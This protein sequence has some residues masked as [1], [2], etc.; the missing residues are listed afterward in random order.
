MCRLSWRQINLHTPTHWTPPLTCRPPTRV[1]R[2]FIHSTA[3][4]L[5]F[6]KWAM[7]NSR[8][9]TT[10]FSCDANNRLT[11]INY[12]DGSTAAYTFDADGDRLNM[13]DAHGITSCAYDQS[14]PLGRPRAR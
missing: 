13:V 6:W 14:N 8:G 7:L 1:C 5:Q 4:Y 10:T 11:G 2:A 12:S 3:V 9:K